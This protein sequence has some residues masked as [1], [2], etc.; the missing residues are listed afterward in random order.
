MQRG[1]IASRARKQRQS[2]RAAMTSGATGQ[3]K[4]GLR[5]CHVG[6]FGDG[7]SSVGGAMGCGSRAGRVVRR[8]GI[9]VDAIPAAFTALRRSMALKGRRDWAGRR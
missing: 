8:E 5:M 7:E 9:E 6:S 2:D 4:S 3:V 1:G